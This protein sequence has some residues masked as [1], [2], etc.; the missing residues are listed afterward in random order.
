MTAD[1]KSLLNDDE[2]FVDIADTSEKGFGQHKI[3]QCL[4]GVISKRKLLDWK[5]WKTM[6]TRESW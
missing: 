6:K 1:V 3:W 5:Q 2:F 4:T